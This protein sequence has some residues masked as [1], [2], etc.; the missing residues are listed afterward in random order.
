MACTP[1]AKQLQQRLEDR[2]AYFHNWLFQWHQLKQPGGLVAV[3]L[4]DGR[5]SHVGG[6]AFWGSARDV[7][8][9]SITRGVRKEVLD[10]FAWVDE[11][12]RRYNQPSALASVD[13]AAGLLISFARS[14][15]RAA[16][17]KDRILRG[18]GIHF[19]AEDDHGHWNGTSEEEIRTYAEELKSALP[20]EGV[21]SAPVATETP[22]LRKKLNNYWHENQWWLGLASLAIGIAGSAA[23]FL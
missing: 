18:D 15:R 7:Y 11:Q 21:Q 20:S 1:V 19:P 14:V 10:Q 8:W 3:D 4:F 6:I 12:V 23:A 17:E 13:Q 16:I 9:D 5:K 22:T 2:R